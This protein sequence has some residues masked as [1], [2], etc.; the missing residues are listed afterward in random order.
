MIITDD[1]KRRELYWALRS[2]II[3]NDEMKQVE[4]LGVNLVIATGEGFFRLEKE[5]EL[6]DALLQ[7]FR[8][9]IEAER[10]KK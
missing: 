10:A 3:T 1:T 8:M 7:Q 2:R 4:E 9:R 5:R 6:N